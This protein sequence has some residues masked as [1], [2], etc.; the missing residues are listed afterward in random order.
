MSRSFDWDNDT[1]RPV[2]DRA[3]HPTSVAKWDEFH[4][5][6]FVPRG[7]LS[8]SVETQVKRNII[9]WYARRVREWLNNVMEAVDSEDLPLC[10]ERSSE[11]RVRCVGANLSSVL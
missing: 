8:G 4:A 5:L 11:F 10:V 6:L 2:L 7:L 1:C 9:K 3:Q